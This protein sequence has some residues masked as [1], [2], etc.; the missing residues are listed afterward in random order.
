MIGQLSDKVKVFLEYPIAAE[1]IKKQIAV[2]R[3][4]E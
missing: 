1:N 4:A 3:E 2:V